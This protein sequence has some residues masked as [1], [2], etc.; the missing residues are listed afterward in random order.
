MCR[1]FTA[2]GFPSLSARWNL[3]GFGGDLLRS[4]HASLANYVG[5]PRLLQQGLSA[6]QHLAPGSREVRK[7]VC[8]R[9][10]LIRIGA[11]NLLPNPSALLGV[12]LHEDWC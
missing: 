4:H 5:D 12:S 9:I 8:R 6:A 7:E 1:L 11:H 2:E 3:E 10:C